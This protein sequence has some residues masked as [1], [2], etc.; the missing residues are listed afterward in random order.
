MRFSGKIWIGWINLA[1]HTRRAD[2]D[3]YQS[4]LLMS[5]DFSIVSRSFGS[6]CWSIIGYLNSVL[7]SKYCAIEFSK[8]IA[9]D[10]FWLIY[11]VFH[12]IVL[13][14]RFPGKRSFYWSQINIHHEF[15]LEWLQKKKQICS[16][17]G[18]R[19]E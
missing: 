17:T 6:R 11:K 1:E 4:M 2:M 14:K 10:F 9:S 3:P 8:T 5:S 18:L 15:H 7:F 13:I 19:I 16:K 12:Q